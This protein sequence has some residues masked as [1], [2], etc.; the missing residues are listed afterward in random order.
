MGG[1]GRRGLRGG[2]DQGK[3]D[4]EAA[5]GTVVAGVDVSFVGF[6]QTSGYCQAQAGAGG[7]VRVRC[8]GAGG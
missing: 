4:F 1:C 2:G 7:L 8:G 3:A 5:A 6:Y